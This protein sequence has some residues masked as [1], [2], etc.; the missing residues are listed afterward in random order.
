[1]KIEKTQFFKTWTNGNMRIMKDEANTGFYRYEVQQFNGRTWDN[2]TFCH[3][4]AEAKVI[5]K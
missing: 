5:I 1:M 2:V 4:L 3:T